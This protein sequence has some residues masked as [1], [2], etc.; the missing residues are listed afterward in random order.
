MDFFQNM[1]RLFSG[2][3]NE[4]DKPVFAKKYVDKSDDLMSLAA[5]L[6]AAPE[7]MKPVYREALE[8]LGERVKAHRRVY[9]IMENCDLPIIVL[10]DLH[11][12]SGPGAATIDYVI[13]SNRYALAVSCPASTDMPIIEKERRSAS[14]GM[15]RRLTPAENCA[16][17]LTEVFKE[18]HLFNKKELRL[19]WPV[20]VLPGSENNWEEIT[21]YARNTDSEPEEAHVEQIVA[22]EEFSE[23]LKNMFKVD[24][25]MTFIS[26]DKVFSAA[27]LLLEYEKNSS[28]KADTK[29]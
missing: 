18:S 17:V 25:S 27:K 9:E 2:K 15:T 16:F 14:S 26:N 8:A 22:P 13:L 24:D 28:G 7:S 11:I 10:H 20:T 5:R 29:D 21:S 19:I 1:F 4:L 12:L 23:F 3:K 6:D